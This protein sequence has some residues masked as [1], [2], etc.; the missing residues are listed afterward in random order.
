MQ[1]IYEEFGSYARHVYEYAWVCISERNRVDI[2]ICW[3]T[4]FK[5]TTFI[6]VYGKG[7]IVHTLQM[8]RQLHEMCTVTDG[9]IQD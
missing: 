6:N 2:L 5:T 9:G 4:S 8:Q 1:S 7:N 3:N